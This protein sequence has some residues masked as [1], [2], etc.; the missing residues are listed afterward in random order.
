MQNLMSYRE[1]AATVLFWIGLCCEL[2]VS[3]SGFAFGGYHEP[4][5]IVAGMLCFSASILCSMDWKKDWWLCALLGV[6]GL[7]CYHFQH[8]ALI[9]R[10]AL[11]LLAGRGQDRKKVMTCFFFGTVGIL[12]LTFVLAAL[13]LHNA[14]VT[15]DWYRHGIEK[16][17]SLG[18]FHPNGFSF[19]W[20]RAFVMGLYLYAG[21]MKAWMFAAVAVVV[22]VPFV[23][24][25]SKMGLAAFVMI[26]AAALFLRFW[27]DEKAEKI[28]YI[29]GNILM[30][31]ELLLIY[32]LGIF[33]YPE[34]S[35]GTEN[36][37]W[38]VMNTV[39]TG[40]LAHAREAFLSTPVKLFGYREV[41]QATEIGFVNA[42]FHE[43]LLFVIIY[44]VILFWLFRRLYRERDRMG[45]LLVLAFT[46]YALAEAYLPYF[47]KNGIWL[48]MIA[49][50]PGGDK[51]IKN[52]PISA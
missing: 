14:L 21:R 46:F 41:E 31:A 29:A 22:A 35:M 38:D 43:G 16:R 4:W 23:L 52:D 49:G 48:L 17:I 47:N 11:I 13:G 42:F 12:L 2:L 40:R 19:F 39:T 7:V 50:L 27:K 32:T 8:S 28:F 9:L 30:A 3:P 44:V 15:E 10:L 36:T 33:P 25:E 45:M 37:Y 26:F 5:I 24:V 1:K 6:Y 18:F 34:H 51:E 20:M